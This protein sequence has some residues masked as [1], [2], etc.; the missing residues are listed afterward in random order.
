MKIKRW[1]FVLALATTAI[2]AGCHTV[3]GAGQDIENGGKDIKHAA[4]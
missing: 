1:L 3:H 2:T 4:H